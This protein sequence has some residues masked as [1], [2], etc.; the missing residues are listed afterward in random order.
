M[1]MRVCGLN[2][3]IERR[4]ANESIYYEIQICSNS[5]G[6]GDGIGVDGECDA[7]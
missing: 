6:Y 4:T 5:S 1:A 3:S 2:G 7:G